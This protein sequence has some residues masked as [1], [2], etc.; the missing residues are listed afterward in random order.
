MMRRVTG[1]LGVLLLTGTV[2]CGGSQTTAAS[3]SPIVAENSAQPPAAPG[4]C[5]VG[6]D[7]LTVNLAAFAS[8]SACDLT[9][10]PTSAHWLVSATYGHPAPFVQFVSPAGT[11]IVG[12]ISVTAP[13]G[14]FGFGSVDIYSSTT[15]IPYEIIGLAKGALVFTIA[16]VQGNVFGG[17]ATI[18]NPHPGAAIDT[19]LIRLTNP[20]APCCS[21]P[22]GLDNI[23]IVR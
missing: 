12:E 18:A 11:T 14:T 10:T 23:R 4:P 2:G 17:F 22:V 5:T 8:L 21:N 19:L 7:G 20:A 16:N 1:V 9:I 15:K 3:P 13:G 6:F